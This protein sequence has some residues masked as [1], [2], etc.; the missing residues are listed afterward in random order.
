MRKPLFTLEDIEG[1]AMLQMSRL[2]DWDYP[3]FDLADQ[4]KTFILS[5]VRKWKNRIKKSLSFTT[6]MA[7]ANLQFM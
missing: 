2:N 1:N 6:H 4:E 5:K 3:I 7:G